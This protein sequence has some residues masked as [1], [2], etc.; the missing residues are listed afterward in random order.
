MNKETAAV[1]GNNIFCR[2][3]ENTTAVKYTESLQCELKIH[4][5]LSKKCEMWIIEVPT[6]APSGL[7]NIREECIL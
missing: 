4:F 1:L 7:S 5:F 3:S 2:H 6:S